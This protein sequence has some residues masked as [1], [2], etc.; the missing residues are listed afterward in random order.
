MIMKAI[1]WKIAKSIEQWSFQKFM[2]QINKL[3]ICAWIFVL[4]FYPD[5]IKTIDLKQ[6]QIFVGWF[7]IANVYVFF[8]HIL[9]AL[10]YLWKKPSE[11]SFQ[12]WRLYPKKEKKTIHERSIELIVKNW[13]T[14]WSK[15]IDFRSW[16]QKSKFW[17]FPKEY[18]KIGDNLERVW[19]LVRWQNNARVLKENID[20]ELLEKVI[21]KT[22]SDD[23]FAPLLREG[24]SLNVQT[25]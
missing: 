18:K 9:S 21:N 24:N 6:Y 25:I 1:V 8:D 14:S 23:L 10:N 22:S 19:I 7:V 4:V 3:V 12:T 17:L 11:Y 13:L 5:F 20:R 2:F 16:S 15:K